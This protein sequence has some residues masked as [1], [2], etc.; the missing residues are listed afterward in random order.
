MHGN[1]T[2]QY[3]QYRMVDRRHVYHSIMMNVTWQHF[4]QSAEQLIVC[5]TTNENHALIKKLQICNQWCDEHMCH[6]M[7]Y[8]VS[9]SVLTY[10]TETCH[11]RLLTALAEYFPPWLFLCDM[12]VCLSVCHSRSYTITPVLCVCVCLSVCHSQSYTITPVLCVCLSVCLSQPELHYHTSAVLSAAVD[13]MSLPYRKFHT[14]SLLTDLTN[15]LSSHGRKV[16]GGS[17]HVVHLF[18]SCIRH[19]IMLLTLLY[20]T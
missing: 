1:S 12:S 2:V 11:Q 5:Y 18:D 17:L 7:F 9:N 13:S 8:T 15:A 16:A 3:L 10:C 4:D 6:C 19:N 20:L 14:P